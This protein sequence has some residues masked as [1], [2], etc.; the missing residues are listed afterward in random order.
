MTSDNRKNYGYLE[1]AGAVH[2][3]IKE[4]PHILTKEKS[5][6]STLG[7]EIFT[8]KM[9]KGKRK[10]LAVGAIH[11]REFLT[12]SYLLKCLEEYSE[13]VEKNSLYAGF[14]VRRIFEEFSLYCVP[15]SN[16]DSVEIALGREK[17][18]KGAGEKSY[19]YKNNARNVNLNANFSYKWESVPKE[20][21]GGTFPESEKE[22]RFLVRL[23][24][25]ENFEM[26]LS[27]HTRGNCVYWRDLGNGEVFPDEKLAE[28]LALECG[29]S[30]MKA[31]EKAEDYSG[32]FENWFRYKFVRPAFCVELVKDE[33][34]DFR[35]G[36]E[37]FYNA[38]D[39]EKTRKALL[40]VMSL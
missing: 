29:F 1:T 32:G 3:L 2:K 8:L 21:E 35:K 20:R 9:G 19:L 7:R 16:P 4:Y 30:L 37:D 27:F 6:F 22:T 26:L 34:R 40:S 18:A 13:A 33:N 15:M 10:I 36:Q 28:K 23:C 24:E 11:G 12:A 5:G 31:T 25:R 38:V 14:S 17:A 39:F